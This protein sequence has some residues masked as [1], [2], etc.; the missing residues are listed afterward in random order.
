MQSLTDIDR[1]ICALTERNALRLPILLKIETRQAVTQLPLM[2]RGSL[3][4]HPVAVMITHGDLAIEAG[5]IWA[6]QVLENLTKKG[7][8]SRPQLTDAAPRRGLIASCSTKGRASSK[9]S[10][11]WMTY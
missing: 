8:L 7:V 5:V 4:R 6:T 2:L 9:R 3:D 1:L 11:P 10:R